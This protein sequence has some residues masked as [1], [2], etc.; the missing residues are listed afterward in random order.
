MIGSL[1]AERVEKLHKAFR[2]PP[3]FPADQ[4]P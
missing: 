3:N 2:P 4:D 1:N